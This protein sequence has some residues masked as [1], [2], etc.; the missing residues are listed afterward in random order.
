MQ[1]ENGDAKL[2]LI[3]EVGGDELKHSIPQK[4]QALVRAQGQVVEA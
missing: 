2:C 3:E 4:L 1:R